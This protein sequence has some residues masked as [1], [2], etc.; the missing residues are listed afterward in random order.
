M[1][2]QIGGAKGAWSGQLPECSGTMS[3]LKSK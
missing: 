1:D 2:S 3:T